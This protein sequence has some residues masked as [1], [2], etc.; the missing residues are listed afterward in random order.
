MESNVATSSS[1]PPTISPQ[2]TPN[3]ELSPPT[4]KKI[5]MRK[6]EGKYIAMKIEYSLGQKEYKAVPIPLYKSE[7]TFKDYIKKR[8][9]TS[10]EQVA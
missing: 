8:E 7:K 4:E 5:R 9:Y 6:D 3:T 2:S 10:D 1:P